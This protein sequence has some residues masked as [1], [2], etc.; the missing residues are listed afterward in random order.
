MNWSQTRFKK[1][2]YPNKGL[3]ANY[4]RNPDHDPRGPWCVYWAPVELKKKFSFC[5]IPK[6]S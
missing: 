2:Q 5:D 4:C 6:C 3:D 1:E